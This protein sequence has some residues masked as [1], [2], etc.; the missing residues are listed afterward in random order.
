MIK[1][2]T[3][4]G[5]PWTLITGATSGIGLAFAKELAAEKRS[6][7]LV[8]RNKD[9]LKEVS[10]KLASEYGVEIKTISAD[11]S[12]NVGINQVINETDSLDVDFL[13]NNAGKEDSGSFLTLDNNEM[14]KSIALNCA[15]PV[16]LTQ[17]FS[18]KM[19]SAGGGNIL[20]IASVVAFQGVPLIANYA[21][22]KSF[23]L[24]FAEGIAAELEP[25][26]VKVSIS[27]P[28]FTNTNFVSAY[29]LSNL[30]FKPL[31]AEFVAKHA[32]QK[33]GKK[34]LIIPG[35]INKFLYF[36]GKYMQSRRLNT[37]AFGRVFKSVVKTAE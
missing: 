14:Q 30:P 37:F 5:K 7:I 8:A 11:L 25:K 15:A 6:I 2:N 28:G 9:K 3:S 26:G 35:L 33:Q 18:R 27:A 4:T 21:A 34:R 16:S 10:E 23:I 24:S 20:F 22:T 12:D 36:S 19:V 31:E 13:I 29:E 32:L 17:H 1:S